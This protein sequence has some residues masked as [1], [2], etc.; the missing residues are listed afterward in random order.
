MNWDRIPLISSC[1]AELVTQL[2]LSLS[3]RKSNCCNIPHPYVYISLPWYYYQVLHQL[4]PIR[5]VLLFWVIF[6]DFS[7]FC[8]RSMPW[9]LYINDVYMYVRGRFSWSPDR[10]SVMSSNFSKCLSLTL[11]FGCVSWR[12]S[13]FEGVLTLDWLRLGSRSLDRDCRL[14]GA[15][16]RPIASQ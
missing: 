3:Y 10:A 16:S 5:H 11:R 2:I 4:Q 13:N 7:S 8:L 12:M 14:A 6:S 15:F 1:T 9:P